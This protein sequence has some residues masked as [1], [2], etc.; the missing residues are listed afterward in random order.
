MLH[1]SKKETILKE[2]QEESTLAI[3]LEDKPINY[4]PDRESGYTLDLTKSSC[5]NGVT[6][7]FDYN[8]WSVKTNYSNYTNTD[9]TRVKC[10]LYFRKI[11]FVEAVTTCGAS[12]ENAANCIT[13]HS[14]L[15]N[16][17]IDDETGDHNV[18][19]IG[20][21]PDNY[22]RF[23]DELWR[24]IGAMNNIDDGTG[25]LESRLKIIRNE[26]IGEYS[27]DNKGDYG[28][29]D[30]STSALQQVLN[31]GA[32][33]NRTIGECPYEQNGVVKTCD[34]STTGLTEDAKTMLG[35][36]VWNLGGSE[37]YK[38]IITRT[39]YDRERSSNVYSGR[40][41][42]WIGKIGLMY[43]SDYGY[44]TNGGNTIDRETCLRTELFYWSR[45]EDCYNNDW[46]YHNIFCQWTLTSLSY[47]ETGVCDIVA[48]YVD[49]N[50][51]NN[52][53]SILPVTYLKSAVKITAGTGCLTDPFILS[54]KC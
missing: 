26:S 23:N 19:F 42:I 37:S 25:K 51:A 36:T 47:L 52:R 28:E 27:W 10:S 49:C 24:I 31:H 32:Y 29:N 54:F 4:I 50:N 41:T 30:W 21:D 11:S 44:A 1:N 45:Y 17:V 13:N 53:F 9:N 39:F 16:E 7:S 46:L 15:S 20:S 34:F 3:Y 40:P 43:P 2:E 8:T 5:N 18:R 38:D 48:G 33:W 35:D 12:G 14:F 22:V 6:I